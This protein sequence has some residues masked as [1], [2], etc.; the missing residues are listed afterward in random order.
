[1]LHTCTNAV[2]LLIWSAQ[3][4]FLKKRRNDTFSRGVVSNMQSHSE[5]TQSLLFYNHQPNITIR[6]DLFGLH[7]AKFETLCPFNPMNNP[8]GI[9]YF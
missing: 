6:H 7:I 1:M 5:C 2:L 3:E 4:L 8:P 9:V